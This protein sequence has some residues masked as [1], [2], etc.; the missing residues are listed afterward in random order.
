MLLQGIVANFA[1]V[2]LKIKYNLPNQTSTSVLRIPIRVMKTLIVTTVM[3]L[4]AVLVNRDSLETEK[5]VKVC[6]Y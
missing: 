4:T 5:L 1:Y 6:L 2:D 3:V